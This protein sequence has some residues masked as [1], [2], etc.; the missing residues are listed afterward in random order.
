MKNL[1]QVTYGTIDVNGF[2]GCNFIISHP[3]IPY[4]RRV[5]LQGNA[6]LSIR[7]SGR[8]KPLGNSADTRSPCNPPLKQVRFSRA[9]KGK[10][11]ATDRTVF[12]WQKLKAELHRR[13]LLCD[14]QIRHC[15]ENYTRSGGRIFCGKGCRN[16]CTLTVNSGFGEAL[17]IAE[18]LTE[19]Q[20]SAL[21]AHIA[22]LRALLPQ[23][24][25]FKS[26]LRMQRKDLGDCPFLDDD[27]AC[28]IYPVRPFAC[29]A[30]LATR[31][32][33]WC[34]VDFGALPALEKQLFM[35]GLNR[36]LVDFPTHYLAGPR[37]IG[38]QMEAEA[39]LTMAQT[40]GFSI[41]GN[42][43]YLVWLEKTYRLHE[44]IAAGRAVTEQFLQEEKLDAPFL[45]M[46]SD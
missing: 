32:A 40:F 22:R 38:E 45:I 1:Y 21:T 29:R 6:G 35:A 33:D 41:S 37:R 34:G 10:P 16:C 11:L 12:M 8:L 3:P 42:L 30:L 24:A 5:Y 23:V 17:L 4:G 39:L 46:L 9:R 25:D 26:Y 20:Y 2:P 7:F 14:Q 18:Q 19:A 44:K 13:Y 31:P 28:E 15:I 36:D 27:G 43:P